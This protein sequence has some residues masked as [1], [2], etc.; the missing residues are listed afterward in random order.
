MATT[1]IP[2][3]ACTERR[4]RVTHDTDATDRAP[5]DASVIPK[6]RDE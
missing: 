5:W 3:P 2:L 6:L 4:T 1:L